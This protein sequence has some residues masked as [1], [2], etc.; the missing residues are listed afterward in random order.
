MTERKGKARPDAGTSEQAK[1][2]STFPSGNSQKQ[3]I[4]AANSGQG[5]ITSLLMTGAENG[6][7]VQD[8]VKLTGQDERSIRRQIQ[9]ERKGGQLILS[10]CKSGYFLP[11]SEYEVRRFIRSMSRRASEIAAVSRAAED[12]L[13]G[14]AGQT[15]LGGW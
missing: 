1:G 6:L 5:S 4:T 9:V 14:M 3:F 11:A 15:R 8:L 12:V 2:K 13:V 10:D 7:T